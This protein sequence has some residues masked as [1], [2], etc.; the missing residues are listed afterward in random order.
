MAYLHQMNDL[1]LEGKSVEVMFSFGEDV[2]LNGDRYCD[3]LCEKFGAKIK[4][5]IKMNTK[6]IYV[7]SM[8]FYVCCIINSDIKYSLK[9]YNED[10][11][12][13]RTLKF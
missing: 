3:E 7:N 8:A 11:I 13:G 12:K 6:K 2:K 5:P 10:I 4:C 9:C 1:I